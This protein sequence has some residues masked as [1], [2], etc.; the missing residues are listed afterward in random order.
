MKK[1]Q[2]FC[3]NNYSRSF[4]IDKCIFLYRRSYPF[5][6]SDNYY[7]MSVVVA[8]WDNH[9]RSRAFSKPTNFVDIEIFFQIIL[10]SK[11][12]LKLVKETLNC[13]IWQKWKKN[14]LIKKTDLTVNKNAIFLNIKRALPDGGT[15]IKNETNDFF[16]FELYNSISLI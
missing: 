3:I 10:F 13:E 7:E 8:H 15:E 14:S 2:Q 1:R 16:Y 5:I 12:V 6:Y 9:F 11:G 4:R